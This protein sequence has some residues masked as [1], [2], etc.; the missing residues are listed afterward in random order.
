MNQKK[1]F[2]KTC[3]VLSLILM[4][5]ALSVKDIYSGAS[6]WFFL[7]G[8]VLILIYSFYLKDKI[9]ITLETLFVLASIDGA[10]KLGIIVSLVQN[11]IQ[12]F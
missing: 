5:I 6:S 12:L 11:L 10:F 8:G 3:G 7:I 9:F 1:Y 4:I 2:F